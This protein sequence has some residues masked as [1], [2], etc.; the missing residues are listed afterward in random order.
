MHNAISWYILSCA[1]AVDQQ[2]QARI[3]LPE[4]LEATCECCLHVQVCLRPQL[5][6]ACSH[7][8]QRL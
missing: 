3:S 6:G 1:A 7:L 8:Q 4:N 2:R 5:L